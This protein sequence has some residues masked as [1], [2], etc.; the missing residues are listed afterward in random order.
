MSSFS[1]SWRVICTLIPYNFPCFLYPLVLTQKKY[2]LSKNFPPSLLTMEAPT[3]GTSYRVHLCSI[4]RFPLVLGTLLFHL[5]HLGG[6]I[7]FFSCSWRTFSLMTFLGHPSLPPCPAYSPLHF[8]FFGHARTHTLMEQLLFR[9][10]RF[11]IRSDIGVTVIPPLTVGVLAITVASWRLLHFL[12][13]CSPF[14]F[15]LL[16]TRT[17]TSGVHHWL[18]HP[19]IS[20]PT[21]PLSGSSQLRVLLGFELFVPPFLLGLCASASFW[22]H[23]ISSPPWLS[24]PLCFRL[25]WSC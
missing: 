22:F 15:G 19:H 14:T 4:T 21:A 12:L 1:I 11:A 9:P 6:L 16:H 13:A 3:M 24:I 17:S 7:F 23:S 20:L 10:L 2:H 5:L 8:T 25:A 18:L